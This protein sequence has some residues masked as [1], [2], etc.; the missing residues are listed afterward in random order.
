MSTKTL[1]NRQFIATASYI[2]TSEA[3]K[4]KLVSL[5][6]R[7]R[8]DGPTIVEGKMQQGDKIKSSKRI[9]NLKELAAFRRDAASFVSENKSKINQK[10]IKTAKGTRKSKTK[11]STKRGL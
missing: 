10:S 5:T 1:Y 8:N 7:K 2:T 4:F 3:G 9:K 6:A 11:S